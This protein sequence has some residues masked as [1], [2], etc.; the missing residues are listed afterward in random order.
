MDNDISTKLIPGTD[1][2]VDGFRHK[3]TKYKTY[4][5]SHFHSDHYTGLT[6]TFAFGNIYCSEST[7]NL[8]E[9]KLQVDRQWLRP[10]KLNTTYDING[11][12]VTLLDANHCPG[13]VLFLF[14][15]KHTGVTILHTGDMR[16]HRKMQ[17][18]PIFRIMASKGEKIN[19]V[20]LDTTY[21]R[22]KYGFP[23]QDVAINFVT[24]TIAHKISTSS[25]RKT[26]FLVGSYT[27]GKERV[28]VEIYRRLKQKIFVDVQKLNILRL[29]L[30]GTLHDFNDI[31]T[32]VLLAADV[33]FVNM[34]FLSWGKL[35]QLYRQHSG[36]YDEIVAFKPTGW[37][38]DRSD[39]ESG[40]GTENGS[41]DTTSITWGV[42]ES[43]K[44]NI[45]LYEVPYSEHS[46]FWELRE[47]VQ[48]ISPISIVPTV[49][50]ANAEE[51]I[52]VLTTTDYTEADIPNITKLDILRS[53][54]TPPERKSPT[55]KSKKDLEK[56]EIVKTNRKIVEFFQP[57]NKHL[58][59][60]LD[61]SQDLARTSDS[62]SEDLFDEIDD[63]AILAALNAV[64]SQVVEV[65]GTSSSS[66]NHGDQD[67]QVESPSKKLRLE[68]AEEATAISTVTVMS[69]SVEPTSD[70]D[71]VEVIMETRPA[72]HQKQILHDMEIQTVVREM[73][74]FMP[75]PPRASVGS[76]RSKKTTKQ[77]HHHN[78]NTHGKSKSQPSSPSSAPPKDNWSI[79]NWVRRKSS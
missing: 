16:Y 55:A 44:S 22:P 28:V 61:D 21:A 38:F 42:K 76:S 66:D 48:F 39:T 68:V 1:F 73:Q 15:V 56:E 62:Q 36:R 30:E 60:P 45:T 64:E 46:S 23:A 77:H 54:A 6:K 11:V 41:K 67:V 10:L 51:I 19:V 26:L 70:D 31:F 43:K 35:F 27:I 25:P 69:H 49:N 52:R 58:D 50:L 63:S 33:H 53:D 5:L 24:D 40:Q 18:Y 20:Y 47:F 4:F 79:L 32:D 57:R 8:V 78:S 2:L 3:C 12:D 9:L 72:R 7:A 74:Q 34:M 65:G 75:P 14:R 59:Q 29:A 71:E 17:D 13:S 37:S